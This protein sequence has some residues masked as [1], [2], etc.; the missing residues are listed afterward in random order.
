MVLLSTIWHHIGPCSL[1]VLNELNYDAMHWTLIML[2][3]K[4]W[5]QVREIKFKSFMAFPYRSFFLEIKI[6]VQNNLS[7]S[8]R[9]LVEWLASEWMS[10]W[11]EKVPKGK[12]SYSAALKCTYLVRNFWILLSGKN[13]CLWDEIVALCKFIKGTEKPCDTFLENSF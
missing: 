6:F 1:L 9:L 12:H 7:L 10:A 8:R 5:L 3:S 2:L 11:M 13:N 4:P